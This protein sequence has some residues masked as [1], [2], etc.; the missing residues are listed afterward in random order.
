LRDGVKIAGDPLAARPQVAC[1][2]GQI[3]GRSR[4]AAHHDRPS[5][6]AGTP[7]PPATLWSPAVDSAPKCLTADR[8]AAEMSAA[9]AMLTPWLALAAGPV[10]THRAG[11]ASPRSEAIS[12]IPELHGQVNT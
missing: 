6:K 2:S 7:K 11:R 3:N 4:S 5:E 8:D 12:R 1:D 10:L 9:L